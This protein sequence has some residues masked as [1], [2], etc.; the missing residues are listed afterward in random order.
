MTCFHIYGFLKIAN[1]NATKS[2]GHQIAPK[3]LITTLTL[4]SRN[5]GIGVFVIWWQKRL[6]IVANLKY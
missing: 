6:Y 5:F 4:V 2:P 1:E 3:L